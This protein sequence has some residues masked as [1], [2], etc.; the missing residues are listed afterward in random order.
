M[1]KNIDIILATAKDAG[2]NVD[3]NFGF[4]V[5][6][7]EVPAA[8]KIIGFE[9]VKN[10]EKPK[11]SHIRVCFEKTGEGLSAAQKKFDGTQS[12]SNLTAM[13]VMSTNLDSLTTKPS[14]KNENRM[15]LVGLKSVNSFPEMDTKTFLTYLLGKTFTADKIQGISSFVEKENDTDEITSVEVLKNA[16]VKDYFQYT[17]KK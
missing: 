6:A 16:E 12:L 15:V 14:R 10:I 3:K 2:V 1:E 4:N 17:W 7:N 5:Q 11:F 9:V 13:V 8:G